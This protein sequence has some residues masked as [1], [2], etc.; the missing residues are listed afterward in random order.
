MTHLIER[1][2]TGDRR[3]GAAPDHDATQE[4]ESPLRRPRAATTSASASG[5]TPF[6][7]LCD[8][9]AS[10]RVPADPSRSG[11]PAAEAKGDDLAD[12]DELTR[13]WR[14][15]RGVRNTILTVGSVLGVIVLLVF[16]AALLTNTQP[17]VVLSGSMEPGMP[18]GSVV[19]GQ[20][21]DQAE[22]EIGDAVTVERP[23]NKG[24]VTHRI[25]ELM[26][27]DLPNTTGLILRGDAN[28]S[29]DPYPYSVPEARVIVATLPLAGYAA[30]VLQGPA[31]I[32]TLA[33]FLCTVISLMLLDPNRIGE[34]RAQLAERHAERAEKR[35]EKRAGRATTRA[36]RGPEAPRA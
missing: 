33:F 21:R 12:P 2:G 34:T 4:R 10:A 14:V 6:E 25:V 24:L 28:A 30:V 18:V 11:A 31:G 1:P 5:P 23:D 20:M 8:S 29:N 13:G 16:G 32:A 36:E 26:A 3:E 22:L 35:S 9:T 27:G 7:R 19:F 17:T 15:Y